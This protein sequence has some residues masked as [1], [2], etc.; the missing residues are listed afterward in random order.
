[1]NSDIIL[2]REE[3]PVEFTWDTT[4]LFSTDRDFSNAA[5]DFSK[6]LEDFRKY[7][8][9]VLSAEDIL[10]YYSLYEELIPLFDNIYSYAQLS[11]DV[12]TS[13]NFYQDLLNRT[14]M[15]STEFDSATAFFNPALIQV[16]DEAMENFYKDEPGLLKYKGKIDDVRRKKSHTLSPEC[17]LI[18]A[19]AGEIQEAPADIFAAFS[20]ADLRFPDISHRGQTFFLTGSSFVTYMQSSDRLFREK[21]F[22]T[23][24]SVYE[25]YKNTFAK[26]LSSQV[27]ALAFNADIRGYKDALCAS[28]DSSGIDTAVYYNLIEAVHNNMHHMHHYVSLRKKLLKVDTLHMYDVYAPLVPESDTVI[29]FEKAKENVLAA[30]SV[31]GKEYTD[32]LCE[33]FNNRWIDIYENR[34]KRSGAYSN[35]TYAHPYVLLN[36]KNNLDS[37][38]TLAHE[39]GHAMHSYLSTKN[40]SPLYASYR[41]FVAEVASTCN[42]ALLMQ[43]LLRQTTDK[44]ERA[45]LINYFLEQ[46][47]ST[48][49]RQTMFAEFE[50]KLHETHQNGTSLTAD[51]ICNIYSELNHQYFGDDMVIDDE[52][53]ME[54]ARIPHFYYNFYVYQYATGFSA[55][56]A[57]SDKILKE[58]EPAVKKYLN[59]LSSGCTKD[60]VSLLLD[61]GVD[62]RGTTAVSSALSV[63]EELIHELD[64]LMA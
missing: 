43:Y 15:L 53:V 33:G 64:S 58:G 12:D 31:F 51:T 1:M 22:K 40:Q 59:F 35:G 57:L 6:R 19:K 26:T 42:E 50:L 4:D 52:I 25:N 7:N 54:W 47:K 39:M 44:K 46:F 63:F 14:T 60:P 21:V 17:E 49:F 11:H 2:K 16:S 29:P 13:N 55:A 9:T 61:A 18:M 36:Y 41:L 37:E 56:I 10:G 34:Q 5:D 30:M 20:Y 38:F 32:V 8:K 48:L 23:F 3:V 28:L 45:V 62:M 27:K 24:Y